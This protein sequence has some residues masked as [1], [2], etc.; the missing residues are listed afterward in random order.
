MSGYRFIS[1]KSCVFGHFSATSIIQLGRH[2]PLTVIFQK[3][4]KIEELVRQKMDAQQR[5]PNSYEQRHK[6]RY[7]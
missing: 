1:P 7:F 3:R 6:I 5:R 4:L 2:T